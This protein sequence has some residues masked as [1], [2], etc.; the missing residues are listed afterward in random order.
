MDLKDIA[1]EFLKLVKKDLDKSTTR[2]GRIESDK[3]SITLFTPSHIQFAR[4]GRGAGKMPPIEP[5]VD[6]VKQKGLVKSNKEAL[7]TAWAIA[8][9]ISK[10]GTKN[11][12]KN[13]PNA[14]EEAIDKYFR[15]YQDKL[16]EKYIDTLSE[17]LEEKYRDAIP[18]TIG[19]E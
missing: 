1:I 11:Y 16:N 5:L 10:K 14:I 2:K 19:K 18:P 4:Y 8:K 7:G 3:D 9:S 6:W 13:A 12:V 15:P 17:E